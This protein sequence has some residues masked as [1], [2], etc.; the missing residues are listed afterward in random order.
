MMVAVR[1]GAALA[2]VA[3]VLLATA[4]AAPATAPAATQPGLPTPLVVGINQDYWPYEFLNDRGQPDGFNV[5]MV[6][7][8]AGR[9]GLAV[10]F[11]AGPWAQV[12]QALESGR[13]H[14]L[15]IHAHTEDEWK[16][17]HGH[18][19]LSPP[20]LGGGKRKGG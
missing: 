14:A 13:I 1:L 5:D 3:R 10:R 6:R 19:A 17:R 11:E 8:V 9:M 20:C 12:R 15:A 18:V 4:T 2:V 16:A 7:A